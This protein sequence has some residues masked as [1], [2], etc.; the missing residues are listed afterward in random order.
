MRGQACIGVMH[1]D[2]TVAA[3]DAAL[4]SGTRLKFG[5]Q[6]LEQFTRCQRRFLEQQD[7]IDINLALAQ[8]TNHSARQK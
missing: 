5:M 8:R 4:G 2:A 1:C 6:G 7:R 3:F